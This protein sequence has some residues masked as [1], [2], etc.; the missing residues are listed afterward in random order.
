MEYEGLH[1]RNLTGHTVNIR[2]SD[3]ETLT[4]PPE[5]ITARIDTEY[6]HIYTSNRIPVYDVKYTEFSNLPE[7]ADG[8]VLVVSTHVE[9]ATNRSDVF[10][11]GPL[12]KDEAGR[13]IAC[14]GLKRNILEEKK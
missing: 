7:P 13:V 3:G 6:Y 5:D 4:L 12:I 8:T 2:L 10:S 1:L 11:P 9:K 14:S